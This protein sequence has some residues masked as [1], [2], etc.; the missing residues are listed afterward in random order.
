MAD[1]YPCTKFKAAR[2]AICGQPH[3]P[4]TT[5]VCKITRGV[6]AGMATMRRFPP[7]GGGGGREVRRVFSMLFGPSDHSPQWGGGGCRGGGLQGGGKVA[8]CAAGPVSQGSSCADAFK[9]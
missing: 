2:V 8:G 6:S 9:N 5:G 1:R 7:R 4:N 3:P